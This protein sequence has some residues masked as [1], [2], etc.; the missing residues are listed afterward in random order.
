MLEVLKRGEVLS[1][2][3]DRFQGSDR[4]VTTVKFLGGNIRLPF[5]AYK[6]ASVTGAP[7]GVLVSAK[8]GPDAYRIFLAGVIRVPPG[9]GREKEAFSLYAARFA[10]I[11]E[12][13]VQ[14]Y[15]YQFFNFYDLW[16]A[17]IG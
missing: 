5:A 4:N 9:L 12:D 2:M 8:T 6:L 17:E 13:Y 14:E 3:G 15:P 7:I 16:E 10:Q 11:L 1:M